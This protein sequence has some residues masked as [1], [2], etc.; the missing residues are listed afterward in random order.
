MAA[1]IDFDGVPMDTAMHLLDLHWN[2]LH[3]MYLLTYRPAFMDSLLNNGPYVSKLLM[4]AIYIQSCLYSDRY[5]LLPDS[6]DPRA[7]GMAF[8]GRFKSLLVHYINK[9]D[10]PT[11]V[12]LFLCGAWYSMANRVLAGCFVVWSTE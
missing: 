2:R 6:G 11:V 3:M 7:S 1:N 12:A 8:Y 4:N 5:P 10:L 9:P